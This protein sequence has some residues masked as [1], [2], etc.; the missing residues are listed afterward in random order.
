MKINLSNEKLFISNELSLDKKLNF[1]YGKNGTGKSTLTKILVDDYNSDSLKVC[2]FQGFSS[3]I[4]ENNLLNAIILGEKNKKIEEEI[5]KLDAEK[6]LLMDRLKCLEDNSNEDIDGSKANQQK[7]LKDQIVTLNNKEDR[8]L[9]DAASEMSR[10]YDKKL[11]LDNRT[12]NKNSIKDK[13]EEARIISDTEINE[14]K[15]T[16]YMEITDK[17]G[18]I[19][20]D[21]FK[22]PENFLDEVNKVL[23]SISEE[24]SIVELPVGEEYMY[25]EAGIHLHKPGE[26]CKFCGNLV[27]EERYLAIKKYFDAD[28]VKAIKKEVDRMKEKIGEAISSLQE[29][30]LD[31]NDLQEPY[32]E[33]IG[34][35]TRLLRAEITKALNG[36]QTIKEV[37]EKK[38]QFEKINPI[39]LV[40]EVDYSIYIDKINEDIISFNNKI[41]NLNAEK[42][43][44]RNI[45]ELHH[46]AIYIS[47]DKYQDIQ[48]K[49]RELGIDIIKLDEEIKEFKS[50]IDIIKDSI[51]NIENNIN[52][53]IRETQSTEKLVNNI[54]IKLEGITN[55][56]LILQKNDQE[57]L[58]Y[59]EIKNSEGEIRSIEQLST[60]EKNLIAFLYF[61]ESLQSVE[62]YNKKKVIIFDDPMN[63]NDD[64]V[65]YFMMDQLNKL[66]KNVKKDG[67]QDTFV[68]LT[69]NVFFYQG[70]VYDII[71]NRDESY[72]PYECNNFYKLIRINDEICIV[73]IKEKSDDFLNVYDG[74]W[75]ELAFLYHAGKP[76]MMLNPMRRIIETFIIFTGIE[77]FYTNNQEAKRLLNVN[78]HGNVVFDVDITGKD[79]DDL[80]NIMKSLFKDNNH[81]VHF[82]KKWKYWK[83]HCNG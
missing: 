16:L 26:K 60:G 52:E 56:K 80:I 67:S 70:I 61:L 44:A 7:K 34:V 53:L 64:T 21:L 63:S 83:R 2:A 11:I 14:A 47:E 29:I 66:I 76:R 27:S 74:L 43:Q 48:R 36:F 28:E 30:K 5:Q 75:Y 77:G 12:Y 82:N 13:I 55:F 71:N 18:M 31:F 58:E 54:N 23:G 50:E 15:E 46:I 37:L 78:S 42:I 19:S 32:K 10:L 73:S 49:K 41:D 65:Q 1:I 6:I 62:D 57:K 40:E 20:Y 35:Q 3:I 68:L 39:I 51:R 9:R 79:C 69:H 45:L 72:Q 22:R 59:Y 24:K 4:G 8:F 38:N 33:K 25:L 81:E 17:V